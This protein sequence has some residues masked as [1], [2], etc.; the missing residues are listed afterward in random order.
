M[1]YLQITQIHKDY[2]EQNNG[3]RYFEIPGDTHFPSVEIRQICGLKLLASPPALLRRA[4]Q[5]SNFKLP[6]AAQF[7]LCLKTTPIPLLLHSPPPLAPLCGIRV[8][9]R[10]FAGKLPRPSSVFSVNSVVELPPHALTV[11]TVA[12]NKN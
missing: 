8:H 9:P 10:P 11:K 2:S 12:N 3:S 4:S 1:G 6:K 7:V 5:I